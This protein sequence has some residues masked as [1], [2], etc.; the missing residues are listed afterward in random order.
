MLIPPPRPQSLLRSLISSQPHSCPAQSW[1][2]RSLSGSEHV[3][4]SSLTFPR[5]PSGLATENQLPHPPHPA[6]S[7]RLPPQGPCLASSWLAQPA[8]PM[9]AGASLVPFFVIV[10]T[11]Q[12]STYVNAQEALSLMTGHL[13]LMTSLYD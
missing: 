12:K 10:L 5:A 7:P 3:T 4:H 2:F 13:T 1:V 11:T 6:V 8:K 9:K